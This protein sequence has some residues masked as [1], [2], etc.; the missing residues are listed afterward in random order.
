M[1]SLASSGKVFHGGA[2]SFPANQ[3]NPTYSVSTAEFD[4]L[5]SSA[6]RWC[7]DHSNEGCSFACGKDLPWP[8]IGEPGGVLTPE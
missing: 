5:E 1:P 3:E 6:V 2:T 4:W 8:A 7:S